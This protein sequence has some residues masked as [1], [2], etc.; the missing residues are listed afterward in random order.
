[1]DPRL[2]KYAEQNAP[3]YTSYPTAPHFTPAVSSDTFRAWL[4]ELDIDA[5]LSLYI[6]APYCRQMCWYCGCNA[7]AALRDEPIALYVEALHREIDAVADALS[8]RE[9][10]EIHWGGGTPNTLSPER[11][12]GVV[13]HLRE[14][15]D[16]SNVK[17]HAVEIDPRLLTNEQARAMAEAGVNRVSLGVQDLEPS[18]QAAIGRE[19]PFELVRSAVASLR[20]AGIDALNF[21]LMYGLPLQTLDTVRRTAQRAASL[22][23]QRFSVF[24]YAHVPWFKPRQ[25]LIDE[26]ALPDANARYDLAQAIGETLAA[27]GYVAVGYDH[28]AL[29]DDPLASSASLTRNFQGFVET[30]CDALV[31]LG[32]SAISTLPQGYAQ[33]EPEVGA[34]RKAVVERGLAIKRGRELNNEDVWRRE[35]IM[36]L[37]C[38]FEV[39]LADFGG[40]CAFVEELERLRPLALDGLV[41]IEN[42]RLRIPAEARPF[43]RLVAQAFDAYANVGAARHS[44]AV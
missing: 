20:A 38:Q 30:A 35:L 12:A 14:R 27:E 36:R 18:V 4:G 3:R 26:T 40:L 1:M 37:L 29:P 28:Y 17:R 25:R 11:F 6:H 44:R 39:D 5:K 2:L 7:Y 13:A 23:P 22:R 16:L 33:S 41:K 31:G 42:G 43:A 32:P 9:V 10:V 19:Q 8:A 34:W 15:L 21:D 24:G